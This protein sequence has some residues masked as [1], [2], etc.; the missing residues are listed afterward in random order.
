VGSEKPLRIL[1]VFAG[2]TKAVYAANL[3][4]VVTISRI[5]TLFGRF[6]RCF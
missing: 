5:F 2:I 3:F 4:N 6:C 1:G